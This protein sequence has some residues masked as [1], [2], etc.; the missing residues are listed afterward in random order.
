MRCL[1]LDEEVSTL[2]RESYVDI[3][4]VD[5]A[6]GR[7]VEADEV[8]EVALASGI[9]DFHLDID[10]SAVVGDIDGVDRAVEVSTECVP[11]PVAL[12]RSSRVASAPP[13]VVVRTEHGVLTKSGCADDD[14]WAVP[15]LEIVR[16]DLYSLGEGG[17]ILN[18]LI[19]RE[20]GPPAS[21]QVGVANLGSLGRGDLNGA[22]DSHALIGGGN[23]AVRLD[24][25]LSE[26][27]VE[28]GL[29]AVGAD[30]VELNCWLDCRNLGHACGEEVLHVLDELHA[31]LTEVGDEEVIRSVDG[32]RVV[33]AA[34]L[35]V[36]DGDG[37]GASRGEVGCHEGEVIL[38]D[39]GRGAIL[40]DYLAS[41]AGVECGVAKG[42][43]CRGVG[44]REL[45]RVALRDDDGG[46][47][48][49]GSE[50]LVVAV[51]YGHVGVDI[52][53]GG[54]RLVILLDEDCAIGG[55]HGGGQVD[56]AS[57]Y[58]LN[59][60]HYVRAVN[61]LEEVSPR[62]SACCCGNLS[63]VGG[64]VGGIVDVTLVGAHSATP[65]VAIGAE[66]EILLVAFGGG[67]V[68][69]LVGG[70]DYPVVPV[71]CA[72]A[73]VVELHDETLA[74][75]YCDE[76]G[77]RAPPSCGVVFLAD[78][79]ACHFDVGGVRCGGILGGRDR[80]N[81]ALEPLW[82]VN[83]ESVVFV[84]AYER[85]GGDASHHKGEEAFLY[86]VHEYSELES[87]VVIEPP[88]GWDMAARGS[89]RHAILNL[90]GEVNDRA[91]R[92]WEEAVGFLAV[93][94]AVA[95][96][97]RVGV[98]GRLCEW[99]VLV[100]L[101]VGVERGAYHLAINVVGGVGSLS[102]GDLEGDLEGHVLAHLSLAVGRLEEAPTVEVDATAILATE[103]LR[104]LHVG[105]LLEEGVSCR[106]VS[107]IEV[108]EAGA[109]TYLVD[110]VDSSLRWAVNLILALGGTEEDIGV[111]HEAEVDAVVETCG[112]GEVLGRH[113][114][115]A[116][117]SDGKT[118]TS[119]VG[120]AYGIILS[121]YDGVVEHVLT[122]VA[123]RICGGSLTG[124]GV[125]FSLV[126]ADGPVETGVETAVGA[127][128]CF[129]EVVEPRG[130]CE[131]APR[132]EAVRSV[133]R[134]DSVA[135]R[136]VPGEVDRSP[137]LVDT[138]SAI[139]HI[140]NLEEALV[141]VLASLGEVSAVVGHEGV[142]AVGA[143]YD[144]LEDCESLGELVAEH[145]GACVVAG[146][147]AASGTAFGKLTA[148]A[149]AGEHDHSLL[150]VGLDLVEHLVVGVDAGIETIE[151]GVGRVVGYEAALVV[152]CGEGV[153]GEATDEERLTLDLVVGVLG[154]RDLLDL[155]ED[156]VATVD[157]MVAVAPNP[158]VA[159][160]V[161]RGLVEC[162]VG[163]VPDE[164]WVV[165]FVAT[166]GVHGVAYTGECAFETEAVV[167]GDDGFLEGGLIVA[168]VGSCLSVGVRHIELV[169]A[170][171]EAC[172]KKRR[173]DSYIFTFHDRLLLRCSAIRTGSGDRP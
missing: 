156:I 52:V 55:G 46:G 45:C 57:R 89:G 124:V 172:C 36:D 149:L 31:Y 164:A 81:A 58:V 140:L 116:P 13:T 74:R 126:G 93:V 33:A 173:C 94:G 110:V 16:T 27:I 37:L 42:E 24:R 117:L 169:A 25:E 113:T 114:A 115:I 26:S 75:W 70:D 155:L 32:V 154:E 170:G 82:G 3:V 103:L 78:S 150:E 80:V 125:V 146:S 112:E 133:V 1:L 2:S 39:I 148:D 72:R 136:S 158:L 83:V 97:V 19:G 147:G 30:A 168:E 49:H 66:C 139:V 98:E 23:C 14:D 165:D 137:L 6:G 99:E 60:H 59:L 76:V 120:E 35:V 131:V 41:D 144:V 48:E 91:Y 152:I 121:S 162:V 54:C 100:S 20:G 107:L 101:E 95:D 145:E 119:A 141:V 122:R 134:L 128:L 129:V 69:L 28:D 157:G 105:D 161:D 85:G 127:F 11:I 151:V 102:V 135:L 40:E 163:P 142:V 4:G 160:F 73:V 29:R 87:D 44:E 143:S 15:V 77:E 132:A 63:V 79:G 108:G 138:A 92:P 5:L 62:L 22:R 104:T 123:S 51:I 43:E 68:A 90:F 38:G 171:S 96:E 47:E 12:K 18:L 7:S 34:G 166:H 56:V 153:V 50:V 118:A 65:A 84:T 71:V 106:E 10:S 21:R 64:D 88:R 111:A 9:D 53:R 159:D 8:L 109:V 67:R 61:L 130:G 17:A 86:V 167:A